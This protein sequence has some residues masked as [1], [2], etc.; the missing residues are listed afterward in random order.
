MKEEVM[1]ILDTLR[2][3]LKGEGGDLELVGITA[4]GTVTV[5]LIGVCR[6]CTGTLWTHKLRI[7]RAI[8]MKRPDATVI[9]QV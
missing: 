4:D 5:R 6:T 2:P 7:E 8:K 1:K 9:V 3:A